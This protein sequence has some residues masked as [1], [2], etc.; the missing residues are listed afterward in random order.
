MRFGTFDH[1]EQ[2]RGVP[3]HQLYAERLEYLARADP[4]GFWAHFKSEHHLTPLDAAPCPS[5]FLAAAQ[6]TERIRLVPLVYLLP[7][8][9]RCA[10]SRRSP[11]STT[12]PGDGSRSG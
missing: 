2:R 8:H 9:H 3:L 5:V 12:S 11:C 1:M 10:S 7:F 4:A 6:R